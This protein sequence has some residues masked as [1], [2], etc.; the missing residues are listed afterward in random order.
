MIYKIYP[1]GIVWNTLANDYVLRFTD[2][3]E[4]ED[5]WKLY[6]SKHKCLADFKDTVKEL[7]TS[8]FEHLITVHEKF[9]DAMK[10]ISEPERKKI[11]YYLK[12]RVFNYDCKKKGC[13]QHHE[14]I[15][16]F[17]I[18]NVDILHIHTCFY[19]DISYI[20]TYK[21]GATNR[22]HFDLDHALGK[23]E[24]PL[25]ALSLHNFVPSCTICNQRLKGRKPL[26]STRDGILH[27]APCSEKYEGDKKIHLKVVQIKTCT[28]GFLKHKECYLIH[29]D[30]IDE[31]NEYVRLF[32]LED[33]YNY[34]KC[35]ALRLLDLKRKY[36]ASL[37]RKLARITS[38]T[39]DELR[40][41]IF[42]KEFGK[43]NHRCFGKL[44]RDIL[45]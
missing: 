34:H 7:M 25:V 28:S 3:Q 33:R 39:T 45:K 38:Q 11:L 20:N 35:E 14:D 1:D 31:Y 44:R 2:L 17:F 4:L 43:E 18:D 29:F 23:A 24:C 8:S 12:S 26:A 16:E 22:S 27:V 9:T 13:K 30:A 36:P 5:R 10:K 42:G 40:E 37:I 32:K 6:K 15:A 21:D 41:D 19:C